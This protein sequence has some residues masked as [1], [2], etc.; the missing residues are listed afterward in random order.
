MCCLQDLRIIHVADQIFTLVHLDF[1]LNKASLPSL[2]WFL[3]NLLLLLQSQLEFPL[4][5]ELGSWQC[6]KQFSQPHKALPQLEA[7]GSSVSFPLQN[8]SGSTDRISLH[9]P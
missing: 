8:Q 3:I 7:E 5:A 4:F 1:S 2:Q 9:L 6:A